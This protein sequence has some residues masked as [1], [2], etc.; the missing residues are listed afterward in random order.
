VSI[1][2]KPKRHHWWPQAQSRHWV[3]AD[4]F[5][6]V[7]RADGTTFRS[8][9]V[10]LGVESELYTRFSEDGSKDTSIEEWFAEAI[11]GPSK[12]M[13]AH[14]LD[15]SNRRRLPFQGRKA[16]ADFAR[17]VGYRINPY[18]DVVA[19]HDSVREAVAA[20]VAALVVRHPTYIQKLSSISG[21]EALSQIESK[22]R[23]LDDMLFMFKRFYDVMLT[24]QILLDQRIGNHEYLFADSGVFVVERWTTSSIPFRVHAPI[25]PDLCISVMPLPFATRIPGVPVAEAT[26]RAVAR[27]NRVILGAARRFVFS[28]GPVNSRFV[29][30]NFGVPPPNDIASRALNGTFEVRRATAEEIASSN[31]LPGH[32]RSKVGDA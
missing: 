5:V 29:V 3:A 22:N 26:N 19:L 7:T 9:P 12:T 31:T 32:P 17:S 13:I 28:K 15:L 21:M 24:S 8:S 23:T 11:D 16:E 25:T 20:Y 18:V 10:N 6:C 30:E 1:P 14:F 4:G 27:T 2:A